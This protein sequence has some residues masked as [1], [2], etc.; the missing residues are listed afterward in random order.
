MIDRYTRPYSLGIYEEGVGGLMNIKMQED[1]LIA[2]V[3]R[4]N[5]KLPEAM[6]GQLKPLIGQRIA[7]LR[8]DI[9]DKAYLIRVLPSDTTHTCQLESQRAQGRP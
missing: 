9:K 2:Q 7:I 3:G 5:L 4:M 8:T 1:Y 6:I